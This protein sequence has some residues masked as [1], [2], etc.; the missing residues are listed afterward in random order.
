MRQ[1]FTLIELVTVLVIIAALSAVSLPVYLDYR[2]DARASAEK[3]VVGAVR[4][5][6]H[7]GFVKQS[8]LHR[9]ARDARH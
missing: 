9:R 3:G 7:S 4:T 1:G 8:V 5:A 2:D 6:I